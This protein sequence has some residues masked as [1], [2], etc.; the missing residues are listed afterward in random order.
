MRSMALSGSI[1][2]LLLAGSSAGLAGETVERLE[3][4]DRSIA[5][6]GGDT[7][8]SSRSSLEVCSRS[9]CF[10]LDSTVDGETFVHEVSGTIREE[11]RRVRV[12]NGEVLQWGG[13]GEPLEVTPD[14]ESG[15]R[16]WVMARVYF[17]F[18]P[19]RL[20]DPSVYK[21]DQGLETWGDRQLHRVK[22][23]F[24]PGSSSDADDE[25]LYWFDPESGRV[26]QFAYSYAGDPGGL[27]FRRGFNYRRIGG[28]LFFDQEN[29]GV[30]GPEL[31]VDLIDPA[32]VETMRQVSV[33]EMKNIRVR[34]LS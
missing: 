17:P 23:T 7:Y 16:N 28:I 24:T 26:E 31:S 3:V 21:T 4:V 6:H 9:G 2:L 30:E 29:L 11:R 22:I 14:N 12:S 5:Y 13:D 1:L 8:R 18:L 10:E 32:Y 25:Y 34:P 19:Y 27:R 20:N 15:L 33:V